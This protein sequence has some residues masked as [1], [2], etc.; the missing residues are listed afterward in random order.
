MYEDALRD[1]N[2][3]EL[4]VIDWKEMFFLPPNLKKKEINEYTILI[5]EI[6]LAFPNKSSYFIF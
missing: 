4:M 3:K 6:Y 1:R 2:H 5:W